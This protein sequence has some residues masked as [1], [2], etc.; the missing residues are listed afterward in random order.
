MSSEHKAT[1]AEGRS[2]GR[3]VRLYLEALDAAKPKR[4]RRRTPES[5]DRRIAAIVEALPAASPVRKLELVQEKI[6]LEAEAASLGTEVDLTELEEAFVESAAAYGERK[7][8]T[9]PAWRAV[10]VPAAVL[11]RAG[12]HRG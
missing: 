2:Q 11:K 4:G 6:D 12:I 1:L 8:I 5:I 7:G 3:A 10:G 9:Y